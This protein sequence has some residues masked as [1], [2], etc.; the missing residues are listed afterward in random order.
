MHITDVLV[1]PIST[2][3]LVIDCIPNPA[4]TAYLCI[5]KDLKRMFRKNK[6]IRSIISFLFIEL[7]I[8]T[9][10]LY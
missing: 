7:G 6:S 2:T 9:T 1:A 8:D 10:T 4:R 5:S 3:Q